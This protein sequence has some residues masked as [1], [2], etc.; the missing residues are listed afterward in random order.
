MKTL[1]DLKDKPYGGVWSIDD[2][3][4]EAVHSSRTLQQMN[5]C[6]QI[7]EDTIMLCACSM[8]CGGAAHMTDVAK[9]C[10]RA[11]PRS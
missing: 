5:L 3:D 6:H 11:C 9:G 4:A 2:Q 7:F 8:F 1:P 10:T